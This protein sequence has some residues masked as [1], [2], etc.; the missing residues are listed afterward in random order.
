MGYSS[1]TVT[2]EQGV[3]VPKFQENGTWARYS[4]LLV[5][6]R[7]HNCT[8]TLS[9]SHSSHYHS[10]SKKRV[11]RPKSGQSTMH[12]GHGLSLED[13]LKGLGKIIPS[14]ESC[15]RKLHSSTFHNS[16]TS[17]TL[18]IPLQV[19]YPSKRTKWT[20]PLGGALKGGS[21]STA[22]TIKLLGRKPY[23]P[24]NSRMLT[25]T[26]ANSAMECSL[27]VM[28]HHS[29]FMRNLLEECGSCR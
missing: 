24:D 13:K 29:T 25:I 18:P 7:D 19:P 9:S 6:K 16:T 10:K 1:D 12:R 27:A 22:V 21:P 23:I 5:P 20:R 17:T 28:E 11:P 2:L 3:G 4:Q 15:R 26:C 14:E 8:T